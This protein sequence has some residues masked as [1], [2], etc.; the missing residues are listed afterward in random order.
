MIDLALLRNDPELVIFLL[1]KKEPSYDVQALFDLDLE[2]RMLQTVV[3]QLRQK[4]N[5]LAALGKSGITQEIKVKL[6]FVHPQ[7]IG[8]YNSSIFR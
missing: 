4:K 5:E 1:K 6:L 7:V 8:I 3:D 2:V